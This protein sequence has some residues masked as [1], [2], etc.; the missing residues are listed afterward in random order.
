MWQRLHRHVYN[1]RGVHR[2]SWP[3][4]RERA[5]YALS[6]PL[7]TM[8]AHPSPRALCA[9][10]LQPTSVH[11][12]GP[13]SLRH[14]GARWGRPRGLFCWF[15]ACCS[16]GCISYQLLAFRFLLQLSSHWVPA[17]ASP[18]CPREGGHLPGLHRSLLVSLNSA[19]TTVTSTIPS[20]GV[21]SFLLDHLL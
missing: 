10:K 5:G 18:S 2:R 4:M 7:W 17:M 11:F 9:W 19:S 3:R 21:I 1:T 16:S 12:C 15:L 8:C 14:Q 20:E 13:S 6:T